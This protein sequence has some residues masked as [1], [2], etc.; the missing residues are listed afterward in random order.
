MG[1]DDWRKKDK[2][3]QLSS[4]DAACPVV[5]GLRCLGPELQHQQPF[6]GGNC[7]GDSRHFEID[8]T[9]QEK[10]TSAQST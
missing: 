3:I 6:R 10:S 7:R 5:G 2:V 8:K 9:S 1:Q 4:P